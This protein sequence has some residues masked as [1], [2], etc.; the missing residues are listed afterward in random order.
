MLGFILLLFC[1]GFSMFT[2][3]L[4]VFLYD[5]NSSFIRVWL[6]ID[7]DKKRDEKND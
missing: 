4:M 5:K 6:G 3:E 1:I 7:E 2:A